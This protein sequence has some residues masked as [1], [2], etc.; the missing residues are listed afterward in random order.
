MSFLS[1]IPRWTPWTENSSDRWPNKHS[2]TIAR[3][4]VICWFF[5]KYLL[6]EKIEFDR[7]SKTYLW[8]HTFCFCLPWCMAAT[9]PS[10][11]FPKRNMKGNLY[12]FCSCWMW[13][14]MFRTN[15]FILIPTYWVSLTLSTCRSCMAALRR[16][17]AG[18]LGSPGRNI[19]SL[20]AAAANLPAATS[21]NGADA[22]C[23]T[24]ARVLRS[25][26]G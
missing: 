21:S 5:H 26:N 13:R 7:R 24:A 1:N 8:V 11:V 10:K 25:P 2:L 14:K 17:W 16:R 22:D 6:P 15:L 12:L 9:H 18:L 3:R 4:R 20:P 23:P 19:S